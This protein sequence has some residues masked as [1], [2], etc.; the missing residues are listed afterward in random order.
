M[1]SKCARILGLAVAVSVLASSTAAHAYTTRIHIVLSNQIREALIAS[2]DGTIQLRMSDHAVQLTARDAD[3]IQNQPLAFRAG[4]IG[5]DNTVFPGLTDPSHAVAQDPYGQCEL[6]YQ[7]ALTE[8]ETAYALGCF[9]HGSTDAVVHHFVNYFTGETFTLTPLGDDR[10]FGYSNMVGHILTEGQIQNALLRLEPEQLEGTRLQ[11]S[12]PRGFVLRAY[13][14]TDSPLWLQASGHA[15]GKLEAARAAAPDAS[16]VSLIGSAGLAPAD[17]VLLSPLYVEELQAQREVLRTTLTDEIARLQDT[18][19]ADGAE[20]GVGAGPD[21]MLGTSDDTTACTASCPT[22]AATYFLY[23]NLLGPRFDAGGGELE[24]AYDKLT[25][26]LGDDLNLF[27]PALVST[28]E[29]LSS[30]LNG[31]VAP[32]GGESDG[33]DLDPATL[34][35]LLGPMRTWVTNT[36]TIDYE[37]LSRSILPDWYID[38]DDFLSGLGVSV[39]LGGLI[40]VLFQPIIDDITGAIEDRVIAEVEMFLGGYFE[41]LEMMRDGYLTSMSMRLDAA[42]DPA[43]G[44]NTLDFLTESGLWAHSFN[45]AAA[46]FA[47]HDILL[48]DG[49]GIED[50]PASFDAS[51]TLSWTQAGQCEYLREAIF[52]L[53]LG[54]DALLSVRQDRD[55][56]ASVP[57]G[58]TPIECHD[59]SL[60]EFGDPSQDICSF[61]GIEELISDPAHSGSITRA[62][63]PEFGM[64]ESGC[65]RLIVPGLP[66]PPPITMMDGGMPMDGGTPDGGTT[67]DG[68]DGGT[69]MP[70]SGGGCRI[71]A[72]GAG[73][74]GSGSMP[75]ALLFGLFGLL[76]V[77]RRRLGLS[78]LLVGALAVALVGCGGD[79]APMDSGVPMDA[80]DSMVMTDSMLPM[81]AMMDGMLPMMDAATPDADAGPDLRRELL[82][83]LGSSTW[84][85]LQS[86]TEGTDV[87]ERAYELIFR[88][89]S[90]E[91]GELRNPFGPSR[92]RTLRSF[93]V[94]A[95]G[96]TVESTIL[97]PDGW[98]VHPDN[99][100]RQNWDFEIVAGDPRVLLITE[101]GG[102]TEEFVE[103][104]WPAPD[105]G[106]TAEVHVFGAGVVEDAFCTNGAFDS[107][108]RPTVWRFGRGTSAE[109]L[110]GHDIVAG[111]DVGAW[112]DPGGMN[113][114]AITDVPGF[115]RL[116]GT[117]LSD[118]FNFIV[119]YTGTVTH[120][121][122]ALAMR[123]ADDSVEDAVWVFLDGDVGASS[124]ADL[125]LEVHGF[126][127]ADATSD[128]P[129]R[130]VAAGDV[131]IEIMLI[132]CSMQ[133]REMRVQMRVAGGA[134]QNMADIDTLP[135]VDE[136]A[137]PP[138]L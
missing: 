70:G 107:L 98:P 85:S 50:G 118:Q 56:L 52:P 101:E 48:S 9:L 106:L 64:G 110:L 54:V 120:P 23:V 72:P 34:N 42:A 68:G 33:F 131:P 60:S 58:D 135:V 76:L 82:D 28:I 121:G 44:G 27:L 38:L 26:K 59:G 90:L 138:V 79:D 108:D 84:S 96:R 109:P 97:S 10:M 92:L 136:S 128:E 15:R 133:I 94:D 100:R 53:G 104:A 11:H 39:D 116:G 69:T 16:L 46:T 113:R 81:D 61:T 1:Q 117:M 77:R 86:R 55:Y 2:G 122:G 132:R 19:N 22:L 30:E 21:G 78:A 93:S 12:I 73:P 6:L 88:A 36:S 99:G 111:V 41:A 51:H 103:G 47:N 66:E 7:E 8:E 67:P 62:Y 124:T 105:A 29:G 95:D 127:T 71:A 80:S 45:I 14:R 74:D 57:E 37:T 87:V 24:S 91:W 13:F 25:G 31:G 18:G 32:A 5:P 63:P 35:S 49:D 83:A 114:F 129:S 40:R 112:D 89:G 4:A 137:F 119:R 126:A 123:E 130:T 3:A 65:R 20:L 115:D 102:A 134:W 75:A 43:L 125:F 17:Q